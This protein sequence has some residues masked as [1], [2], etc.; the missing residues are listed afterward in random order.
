MSSLIAITDRRLAPGEHEAGR[1]CPQEQAWLVARAHA[2][3]AGGVEFVQLREK[4]L[5]SADL[6]AL[7]RVLRDTLAD[8]KTRLLLNGVPELA[9][10]ANAD[11]VHLPGGWTAVSIAHARQLLGADAVISVACH[12]WRTPCEAREAGADLALFSPIFSNHKCTPG[13]AEAPSPGLGVEALRRACA[14][15]APLPVYALGGVTAANAALCSNAG[16]AGVAAIRLF[17]GDDWSA[18]DRSSSGGGSVSGLPVTRV[19]P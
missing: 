15:A 11:G 5:S 18:P 17:A 3:A 9:L 14:D 2:W 13:S 7:T 10:A 1:L 19:Q 16:A 4:D 12:A 8:T 6:L